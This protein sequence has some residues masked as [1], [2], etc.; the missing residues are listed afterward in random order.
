MKLDIKGLAILALVAGVLAFFLLM[1]N[2]GLKSI[3]A[4]LSVATV[5]G[6]TVSLDSLKGKPY[7]LTFW[8][9]SCSGC[10][11][12]IPAL[13]ALHQQHHKDGLRVIGVAMSYDEI[14]AIQAMRA[15]KGMEYTIAYDQ[16][17][18][19]AQQFDVRVTPTSFLIDLNGKIAM[20]RLGEWDHA[21]LEQKIVEL[22]KG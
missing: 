1:P 17:G 20:H 12:E 16:T 19:L 14:P 18:A 22:L 11:K 15:Q 5:D 3:P 8:A 21:E 10:V 13:Q 6:E 9:T 4:N 2:Q 7:L